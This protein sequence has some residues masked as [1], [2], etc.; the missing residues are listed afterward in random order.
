[1]D[2]FIR[3]ER[4]ISLIEI[5]LAVA[6]LAGVIGVSAQSLMSF[7]VGIDIQE[8]KM[9]AVRTCQSVM[10][11]LREKRVQ[12]KDNFPDGL[13][14]WVNQNNNTSWAS[15]LADNSQ[16]VQLANQALRVTCTN[17][18]G[19]AAGAGDN[20]IIVEVTT[21]WDDRKGRES[22]ASVMSILTNE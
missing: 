8:Q 16:H 19:E 21:T 5:I 15:Y 4:G 14:T 1:M 7:Y 9:E 18:E 17:M 22:T 6:I 2:K 13:L 10:D 20:P 12:Y 3:D 11:G